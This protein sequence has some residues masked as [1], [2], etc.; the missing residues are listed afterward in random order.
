[1]E[2]FIIIVTFLPLEDILELT[3][4]ALEPSE[5][6]HVLDWNLLC[7][8]MDKMFDMLKKFIKNSL[9]SYFKNPLNIKNAKNPL[10]IKNTTLY[11]SI[12]NLL[13]AKKV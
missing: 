3:M 13:K 10:S 1:M 6:H 11:L 9:Q 2:L 5:D 8:C 12:R 7:Y 4:E